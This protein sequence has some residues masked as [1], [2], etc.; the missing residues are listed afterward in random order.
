GRDVEKYKN[1]IFYS[2]TAN[3]ANSREAQAKAIAV[4]ANK[5]VGAL[6]DVMYFDEGVPP[7]PTDNFQEV[8][9]RGHGVAYM[10]QASPRQIAMAVY[11]T[12]MEVQGQ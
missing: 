5:Y 1:D 8:T 2:Y 10:L 4:N 12:L 7:D 9:Y 11:I 3:L 6:Y